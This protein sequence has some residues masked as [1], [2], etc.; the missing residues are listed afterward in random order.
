MHLE[1]NK[2]GHVSRVGNNACARGTCRCG[3]QTAC[4]QDCSKFWDDRKLIDR[5]SYRF[6]PGERLGVVGPNGAGKSTLLDMMAGLLP[7]DEGT[8]ELGET[9]VVGYF[10]QHPPEVDKN[11]KI[12]D[13]IT[14]IMADVSQSCVPPFLLRCSAVLLLAWQSRQQRAAT[15][16]CSLC[17]RHDGRILH[18]SRPHIHR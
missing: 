18:L 4:V 10:A 13:F 8:R 6:M 16:P 14:N 2:Y 9:S 15:K 12:I 3:T 1:W 5:F 17:F 11:L 7:H